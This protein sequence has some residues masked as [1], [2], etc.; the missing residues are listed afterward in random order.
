MPEREREGMQNENVLLG[1]RGWVA[2]G[3]GRGLPSS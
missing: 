1:K 3:V 2:E